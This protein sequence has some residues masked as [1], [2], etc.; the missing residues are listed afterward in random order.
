MT[1]KAQSGLRRRKALPA[2]LQ[3]YGDH[4][5]GAENAV[6]SCGLHVLVHETAEPIASE[7]LDRHAGGR[8]MGRGHGLGIGERCAGGEGCCRVVKAPCWG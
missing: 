4:R 1:R 8:G 3:E 5:V 7:G 2:R 6:T